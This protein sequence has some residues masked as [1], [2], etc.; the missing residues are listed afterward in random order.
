MK[1]MMAVLLA[2]VMVFGLL[3]FAQL[4]EIDLSG[5]FVRA[6][7]AEIVASGN[8]G[9]YDWEIDDGPD[10]VFFTLDS[11]GLLTITGT[12]RIGAYDIDEEIP[13]C[14]Y[15]TQIQS[16]MIGNGVTGILYSSFYGCSSLTSVMIPDSVTSI[17]N[18]AFNGCS[19]LTEITI[20]DSVTS[21]GNYAFSGCLSMEAFYVGMY[22][23]VYAS[24]NGV[25]FN[26]DMTSLI[27]Y[28]EGK[29]D[30]EY[31]I[32]A[33]VTS[34]G[35]SAFSGCSSLEGVTIPE[36][37]TSIGSYAF[38]GCSSL[39]SVTIPEGVTSIGNY[40]FS[41][42]SS[43]MSVT[44][45]GSVTS[46]GYR[47]FYNC[48]SLNAVYYTGTREEWNA[49]G[50]SL[51][52]PAG[53]VVCCA[54]AQWNVVASGNCGNYNWEVDN[55]SRYDV[56]FTLYS[57][58]VLRISG[59]GVIGPADWDSMEEMPWYSYRTQIK[60]VVIENGVTGI[61]ES[62]FSG[63]SILT[64]VTI[65]GSVTSIGSYAFYGCSSLES[66]TIPGS[67]TSIGY[68]A[69][70]NCSSLN[71]VYY[72]GTR[73]EWNA[74]GVSDYN[75]NYAAVYCTGSE[76]QVVKQGMCGRNISY[77]LDDTGTLTLTGTGEMINYGWCS[78]SAPWYS[79][80][81]QIK[82]VRVSDGI[83]T[84]SSS[85]FYMCYNLKS[86]ELPES[87]N[88]IEGCA[89]RGCYGLTSITIPAS[90]TTIVQDAFYDCDG[91]KSVNI[92]D[93]A[94][95]CS[96]EFT[97]EG[98]SCNPLSYAHYLYINGELVAD[99]VIPDVVTTIGYMTF[100]G[101]VNITSITIP[102]CVNS[103]EYGAFLNC[104]NLADIIISDS[105]INISSGAFY[106]TAL[107]NDPEKWENGVLY[108]GNHL[109]KANSELVGT[110]TVKDGTVSITE[111][112][113]ENHNG[114]FEI[115]LPDSLRVIGY[116]AFYNC[117]GLTS[118][119]IPSG[120]TRIGNY[121]FGYCD[122]LTSV[123]I[124]GSVT[125]IG[126]YAFYDCDN[127]TDIYF[128]GTEEQWYALGLSSYYYNYATV[129]FASGNIIRY[130]ANGGSGA[131]ANQSK[132][133]GD[134]ITLS[135]TRPTRAL[136]L[137]YDANGGETATEN[138]NIRLNFTGWNTSPD[139][140]GDPYA[141]G[142]TYADDADLT[143]YAQWKAVKAGALETPEREGYTFLGWFTAR[144][145]GEQVTAL[146]LLDG[147]LTVYAHWT[148]EPPHEHTP[149]QA[150][151]ENEIPATCEVD[152]SCELVVYCAD[153]GEE[154]SRTAQ[155][156]PATGHDYGAWTE[157]DENE[158]R[159][160]C[161]NDP[162]HV[163]TAP[164]AWDAGV[165]VSEATETENGEILYTC[166]VCGAEKTDE[167]VYGGHTHV[168]NLT[169]TVR[170]ASC[171]EDG[172]N[173]FTCVGCGETRTE[174]IPATG[175]SYG[176]WERQDAAYHRQ[177]CMN[178]ASHI[179]TEP[180]VWNGGIV[181]KQATCDENGVMI[182]TCTVCKAKRAEAI[183]ATG[184]EFGAWTRLNANEHKRVCTNDETHFETAA[185]TWNA[186][187]VTKQATCEED[188]SK[189][190]TCTV[191]KT[192]KTVV[193]PAT[194]HAYGAW[195]SVND[196]QHRRVCANDE[197]HI[198][199]GAHTWNSGVVTKAATTTATG[200]KTYTCTVCGKTRT[201]TIP[202][203]LSK[204]AVSAANVSTG[205][206]LTW[207]Q[208][209]NA[210]GY[211][212]VRK[213]GSG[214]Y[215]TLKK[216]TS[217]A[218]VTYTDTTVDSGTQYTYYVRSYRG[219]EKGSYTAK[220]ITFL[221]AITP[222]LTNGS[223]GITVA[224]T[225]VTGASGYYV[226]RKEGTGSYDKV[227]TI[228]GSTTVKYV[229]TAV[230]DDNGIKFTYMVKAYKSTTVSSYT[231]KAIY[232]MTGVAI[233]SLSNS[234]AGTMTVKWAKNA[235]ATGYE[236]QYATN[237]K[238]TSAKTVTVSGASTV[239]KA[240][241]SLT[242]GS[243]YYVRVRVCK[244]VSSVKYYSAWSSAKSVKIAK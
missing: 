195:T 109:I 47:A 3:P 226:Y 197:T 58:G 97:G 11:D 134:T 120:V 84:I 91:L 15:R 121:A 166:T 217:N 144:N 27:Q 145:G 36:G 64:S 88:T 79:V 59:S 70:Y 104:S 199:T 65:P 1:K 189:I 193:I 206:K 22:N 12:G 78:T 186:G 13:W 95:W 123:T 9:Y 21:I 93:L 119:T 24:D 236:I 74:L 208:D 137:T 196:E 222:T 240:I 57:D 42:C 5:L 187:V 191:C 89:F 185:H 159:K 170:E 233:S 154:L 175:H 181:T 125:S 169:E 239:S 203:L 6:Q 136:T 98:E 151:R 173:L 148:N 223:T 219:T 112:A 218:T 25:L 207:P 180:H 94:A 225:K 29:T 158:H 178:D 41:G 101:C 244:T 229:D 163:V 87:I 171:E 113:F 147:D 48:S 90:V 51:Y 19:S 45:P 18:Y 92:S 122:N 40:M 60:S 10:E 75:I 230:K 140:S 4:A 235:K 28:P 72:T 35:S 131:P 237:S 168:W 16:V 213:T 7:A 138:K 44:I 162:S 39:E 37:V 30:T 216:I 32:P 77:V 69:F 82:I 76:P 188:G 80:K 96:I 242:K 215:K 220:K 160:I 54:D 23:S 177:V 174:A 200:V 83:T 117:D 33:S 224:W 135:T 124:P 167:I 103:I 46:I 183:P 241:A 17:G 182:Y 62:A 150:V 68:R 116:E 143:L 85:A 20:P 130:D 118:V 115:T 205:I 43:L 107:Y 26:K 50:V 133:V 73:E 146:T 128:R 67:V 234:A 126:D 2:V 81:D 106:G 86:I 184:H 99:L 165:V 157:L 14:S 141:P 55:G 210:T 49:L 127:L 66:V 139:G 111:D 63:C 194:G 212:V 153:C 204:I 52:N 243:T 102:N 238:F 105:V 232:R 110:Y 56:V 149:A 201:E 231:A 179:N 192:K 156:L 228:S 209:A 155:T 114:L 198:E 164:H 142:A 202:K 100:S 61:G 129:H 161:A 152:G 221:S 71:A 190:C 8:C 132:V 31:T 53:I 34:I 214:S 176:A 108:I 211:Y 227:A 38:S 172:E